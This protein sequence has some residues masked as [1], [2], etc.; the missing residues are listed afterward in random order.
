M[1]SSVGVYLLFVCVQTGSGL[2]RVSGGTFFR[3]IGAVLDCACF[4]FASTAISCCRVIPSVGETVMR[5]L[6]RTHTTL[7]LLHNAVANSKQQ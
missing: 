7:M 6:G 4:P 2:E 1:N 3:N 5:S